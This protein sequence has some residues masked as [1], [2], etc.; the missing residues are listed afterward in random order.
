VRIVV[1][2]DW[3]VQLLRSGDLTQDLFFGHFER[4]GDVTL[5]VRRAFELLSVLGSFSQGFHDETDQCIRNDIR[6]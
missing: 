2:W 1:W 5:A 6:R 3:L 4:Y